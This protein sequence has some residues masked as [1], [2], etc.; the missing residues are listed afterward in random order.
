MTIDTFMNQ[1][2]DS[3]STLLS[4]KMKGNNYESSLKFTSSIDNLI[5]NERGASPSLDSNK[6]STHQLPKLLEKNFLFNDPTT[7]NPTTTTTFNDI[8][9]TINSASLKKALNKHRRYHSFNI[10]IKTDQNLNQEFNDVSPFSKNQNL[11]HNRH[12]QN[13]HHHHNHH[14]HHHHQTYSKVKTSPSVINS[15]PKK[16]IKEHFERAPLLQTFFTYLSYSILHLFGLIR[17]FMINWNIEK[18]Q[19]A[20][21]T[22]PHV[23]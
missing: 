13:N 7:K 21:D 20:R 5:D 1:S 11:K 8:T 17:E 3:T 12:S 6:N 4:S 10:N 18:R 2:A 19:G 23:I 14:N 15:S 9:N 16:Y 22:N